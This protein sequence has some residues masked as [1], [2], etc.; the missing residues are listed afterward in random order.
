MTRRVNRESKFVIYQVL[1]IF[2]VT[3]LAIKGANLDL[4]EVISKDKAVKMSVRDSLLVIIDSLQA[5]GL[6]PDIKITA[7]VT[8]ENTFLKRRIETLSNDLSKVQEKRVIQDEMEEVTGSLPKP[9]VQPEKAAEA[10]VQPPFAENLSLL[11]NTWNILKNRGNTVAEVIDPAGGKTLASIKPGEEM[12][13]DIRSQN[14]LLVR[15]GGREFRMPTVPRRP[16]EIRIESVSS[17]MAGSDIYVQD[18][19]RTTVFKIIVQDQ[20]PDQLDIAFS[21]P[22]GVTGP[23]KDQ[24]GNFV[25]NVS[26]KIAADE[27]KYD[28]WLSRTNPL[29][30]NEGR[31]KVNFFITA[32]DRVTRAR[33]QV[34]DSFVFTDFTR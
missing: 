3:V 10:P 2:V 20:R 23:F 28:Q 15:Y 11:Q 27:Q 26:L 21:G 31:Y 33:V 8:E 34:G 16:P 4:H 14:E 7:A 22:V 25:Y 30:D 29:K 6:S 13:F 32:V 9:A 24:K 12:K 17:K 19:Q 1:Y 5:M 18:L